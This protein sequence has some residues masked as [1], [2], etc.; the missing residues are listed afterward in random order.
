M[1][2]KTQIEI[3]LK[4]SI[5]PALSMDGGSFEVL[6]IEDGIARIR[7]ATTMCCPATIYAV[8]VQLEQALR[9]AV[10]GVEYVEMVP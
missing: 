8:S 7:L 5:G 9:E 1:E 4:D 3:A 2:L 6:D 10:P